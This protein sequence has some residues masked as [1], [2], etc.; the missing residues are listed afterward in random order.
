MRFVIQRVTHGSVTV[1]GNV[2]GSIGQGLVVLVGV[3]Q[4]DTESIALRM[5]EKML[6]LRIFSDQAGKMN[7]SVVD[8]AGELLMI[9]QFTLYADCRKGRRPS[10]IAAGEPAIA[11]SLFRF[12]IERVSASGLKTASG[13][14]AADMQVSLNNDGPVTIVLDSDELGL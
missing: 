11:Q 1:E 7:L 14:F 2:V 3:G 5:V 13:I 6:G 4:G 12:C 8:I 9:S 10:F